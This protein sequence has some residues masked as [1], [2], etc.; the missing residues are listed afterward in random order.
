MINIFQILISLLALLNIQYAAKEHKINQNAKASVSKSVK[1]KLDKK[2]KIFNFIKLVQP[3]YSTSYIKKIVDAIFKYSIKYK[4]DPYIITT[5]AYVESEFNMKSG[6]CVGIMQVY[7]PTLRW[8]D[9]KKE[10]DINTIDGN[11]GLGTKELSEHYNF[12][13]LR[14]NQM[15][16]SSNNFNALKIMWGK[17]NGSGPRSSYVSK[18]FNALR[19]LS[20]KNIDDIERLLRTKPIWVK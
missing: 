13:Y 8:L 2:E 1:N 15:D 5:T 17:Y 16:R 9:P 11:I 20:L 10:Y 12:R 3:K 7:K 14:G 19:I 6:P 4:I 18:T